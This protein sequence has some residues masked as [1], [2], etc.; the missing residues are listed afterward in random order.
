MCRCVRV[1]ICD[2]SVDSDV[3]EASTTDGVAS[4]TRYAWSKGG[5]GTES[6]RGVDQSDRRW[7]RGRWDVSGENRRP[8]LRGTV[9]LRDLGEENLERVGNRPPVGARILR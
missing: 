8:G 2:V 5:E 1:C 7:L 4:Y 3:W 6:D 9:G